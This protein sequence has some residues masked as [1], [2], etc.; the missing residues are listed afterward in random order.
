MP[1]TPPRR[2]V[3][4]TGVGVVS[5][6][7]IGVGPFL[8]NLRAMRGGARVCGPQASAAPGHVGAEVPGFDD[9]VTKGAMPKRQR[10]F[11]KVMCREIELG[12]V[13]AL[14]AVDHANL[15]EGGDDADRTRFGVDFGAN[16][17]FSPPSVTKDACWS[18]VD[19]GDD[20]REFHYDRWGREGMNVLEPLWL[21]KYLPNMPACHIGIAVDARGPSNSLTLDAASGNAALGE[22]GRVIER[23][24]A[25][26]MIAGTTGT[27]L[28]A[29]KTL[30]KSLWQNLADGGDAPPE[31]WCRPFDADRIGQVVGE[32]ACSVILE[33]A[34]HAEARGAT[35]L[36]ELL[37]SATVC[38]NERLGIGDRAAA[39]ERAA[40][41]ALA[42]AGLTA[43]DLGHVNAHG[44]GVRDADAAECRGL[45][46]LLADAP[47]VAVTAL[48]GYFGNSGSGCGVQELAA[49]LLAGR[50][51]FIPATLNLNT[52][53]PDCPL[54]FVTGTHRDLTNPVFLNVNVTRAGQASAAV[55]RV[56]R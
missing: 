7:G 32:A 34:G 33:E 20:A 55:V 47:D 46:A 1:A 18:C 44:L 25:D 19:E 35:V 12:V 24:R 38:V 8:E 52:P 14:Q 26:V 37:G 10:K 39:T 2:R 3:V 43:A 16:L 36:G 54:N 56:E 53:D 13:S 30:H 29:V 4:I 41:A 15:G 28:H 23:D 48:K 31:T 6:L 42:D 17:M 9:G 27:W 49:S 51:G 5:P 21:L 40:R 11:V 45:A 50:A 22:A